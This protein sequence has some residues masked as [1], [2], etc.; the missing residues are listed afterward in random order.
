MSVITEKNSPKGFYFDGVWNPI[1]WIEGLPYRNRIECLILQGDKVY[2]SI[3]ERSKKEGTY[4]I[5]GGGTDKD[6]L[7][8][9]QVENEAKEEARLNIDN[10]L[11]TGVSYI[12]KY[13]NPSIYIEELQ[14]M[15]YGSVTKV[16]TAHYVNNYTG[17]VDLIDRD[18]NMA[19]YGDFYPISQVFTSLTDEHKQ[20][21]AKE[22][23]RL[24]LITESSNLLNE[25][26]AAISNEVRDSIEK[27]LYKAL[28]LIDPSGLNTKKYKSMLSKMT[29]AQFDGFMKKLQQGDNLYLEIMPYKNLPTLKMLNN[30]S[31]ALKI[32]LDEYVYYPEAVGEDA[33]RSKSKC[34][35]GYLPIKRLQQL[36]Y[37]KNSYSLDVSKR[38]L[39]TGQLNEDSKVARLTDIENFALNTVGANHAL[40]EM[41][42]PR[43]D[44]AYQKAEMNRDIM[45]HGYVNLGDLT[46]D[47]E[48]KHTLN[49]VDVFFLGAGIKTDLV[50]NDLTLIRTIKDKN[51]RS[52]NSSRYTSND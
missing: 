21:I 46:E 31:K 37:K 35:V 14:F 16:Y 23:N 34:P 49:T 9:I 48:N 30:A 11:Y 13:D 7:D 26:T 12:T 38:N 18:D 1:I 40:K 45:R 22:C 47:V 2:L 29:N 28:N 3:D 44:D 43:A 51:Q 17:R 52:T 32:P 50:T 41:L 27:Y 42:G 8:V 6:L 4:R 5:P 24:G 39:K 15:Y 10:I 33:I 19:K 25:A 36:L 20:A